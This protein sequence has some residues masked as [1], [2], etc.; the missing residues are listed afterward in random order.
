MER[1]EIWLFVARIP[2]GVSV[3]PKYNTVISVMRPPENFLLSLQEWKFTRSWL[4]RRCLGTGDDR[5]GL[6]CSLPVQFT[7]V[8]SLFIQFCA[9]KFYAAYWKVKAIR[10]IKMANAGFTSARATVRVYLETLELNGS[11]TLPWHR[12]CNTRYIRWL[13]YAP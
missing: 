11:L 12:W 9:K 13:Y 5:A 4:K 1:W 10:K 6:W 2:L 3:V 8:S 7:A